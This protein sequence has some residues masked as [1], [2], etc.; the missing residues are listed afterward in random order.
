M[1]FETHS[2]LLANVAV[3]Q[4]R[5]WDPR[6]PTRLFQGEKVEKRK[7][8]NLSVRTFFLPYSSSAQF[9]LCK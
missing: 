5:R 8:I 4:H 3:G 7:S 9:S 1:H 6:Q 2:I